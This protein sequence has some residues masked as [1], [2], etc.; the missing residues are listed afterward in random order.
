VNFRGKLCVLCVFAVNY[1][2]AALPRYAH[3]C[4]L[5]TSYI[6]C[7]FRN[8]S[9]R[10]LTEL[11]RCPLSTYENPLGKKVP[12]CSL[13]R[14]TKLLLRARAGKAPLATLQALSPTGPVGYV[15]QGT[16]KFPHRSLLALLDINN[17]LARAKNYETYL[18]GREA[19]RYCSAQ[20]PRGSN[21]V[22]P[23]FSRGF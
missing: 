23:G 18:T 12:L 1:L 14:P 13:N 3:L 22:L 2:V 17:I 11:H 5:C 6:V 19:L 9:P 7:L 8:R 10:N 4:T 20:A 16:L 15:T 21:L